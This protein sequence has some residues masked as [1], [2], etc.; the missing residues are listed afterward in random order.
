[1][2]TAIRAAVSAD[3]ASAAQL[4]AAAFDD[5]DWTRW[6]IPA[7][8]YRERLEQIQHLYLTHALEHGVVLVAEQPVRAVAAFVPPNVAS[9]GEDMRRRL[10]E[11]H[12]PRLTALA[13]LALPD[14]PAGS[15]TLATVGVAPD[16]Q[17]TGLG[18][19]AITAGLVLLDQR[20]EPVALETSD[21]RN[22]RLYRRLGFAT[23][24]TTAIPDGPV[25]YSMH[26]PAPAA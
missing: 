17:G 22:V 26:R 24:A 21:D 1:M 25:V 5:S 15:W 6:T 7:D 12:G 9:P 19:A 14:P 13:E 18:T 20:G 2:S 10:A 8:G 3:L 16:R 23:F 4:L 11:L